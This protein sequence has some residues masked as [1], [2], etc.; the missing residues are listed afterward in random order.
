M[1]GWPYGDA[2]ERI[3]GAIIA[4]FLGVWD[5]AAVRKRCFLEEGP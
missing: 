2:F 1:K 3:V 5:A 4:N